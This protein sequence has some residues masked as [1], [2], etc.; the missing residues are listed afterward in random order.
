VVKIA[1]AETY[2]G[3]QRGIVDGALRNTVSLVEFKEYEVMK[4]IIFPPAYGSYG[5]VF[6]EVEEKHNMKIVYLS[7]KD[8]V[9]LNETRAGAAIKDWIYQKSPKFGPPIYEKM[10]PYIK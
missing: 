2:E 9:K 7:D 1:S 8:I 10:I 6:I 3:L 4:N 5:S